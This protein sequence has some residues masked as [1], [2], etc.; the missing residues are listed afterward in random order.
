M[1]PLMKK[2]KKNLVEEDLK[3]LVK[4]GVCAICG[5]ASPMS[6]LPYS[7]PESQDLTLTMK[8]NQNLYA[9]SLLL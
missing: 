3:L 9:I 1:L 6:F 5:F 2:E 7:H 4:L 8:I